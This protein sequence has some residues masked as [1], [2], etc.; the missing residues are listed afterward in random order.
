MDT[1]DPIRQRAR[2]PSHKALR[3]KSIL[4]AAAILY[5]TKDY[6]SIR[7]EEISLR[8]GISKGNVYRYFESKEALFLQLAL[9]DLLSW[10]HDLE[11]AL[12]LPGR[13]GYPEALAD[14]ISE[15]LSPREKLLDLVAMM[16]SHLERNLSPESLRAFRSAWADIADRISGQLRMALP[17][18]PHP[19]ADRFPVWLVALIAGLWPMAN[20]NSDLA[21]LLQCPEFSGQRVDFAQEFQA[22]L[23]TWFAGSMVF[24]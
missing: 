9:A 7:M 22:A 15:T 14:A 5:K 11:V 23:A 2:R 13:M 3:R 24:A 19:A 17:E 1:Q 20:P 4:D 18:L 10:S 12:T 21:A 6:S 16:S 8:A